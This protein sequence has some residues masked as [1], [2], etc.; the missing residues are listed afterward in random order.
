M[1]GPLIAGQFYALTASHNHWGW[2]AWFA[3]AGS[4][5]PGLL[6]LVGGIRQREAVLEEVS[7]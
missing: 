2:F 1:A 6:I 5:L 7:R 3:I 4:F